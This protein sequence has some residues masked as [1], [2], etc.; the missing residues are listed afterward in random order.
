MEKKCYVFVK[1]KSLGDLWRAYI[2]CSA[3][4]ILYTY[5]EKRMWNKI[6]ETLYNFSYPPIW[7]VDY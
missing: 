1:I 4:I 7:N 6:I 2:L 3:I 5:L